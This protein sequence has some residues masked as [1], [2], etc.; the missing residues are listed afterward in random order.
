MRLS[1]LDFRHPHQPL[2]EEERAGGSVPEPLAAVGEP[3]S[4]VL[5][6]QILRDLVD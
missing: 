4:P 1:G 2:K 5:G 6:E 3:A